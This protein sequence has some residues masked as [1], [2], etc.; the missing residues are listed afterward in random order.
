[1]GKD[2][3]KKED[4]FYMGTGRSDIVTDTLRGKLKSA[5]GDDFIEVWV[6]YSLELN[7]STDVRNPKRKSA[8]SAA[9]T[10]T[11]F[12]LLPKAGKGGKPRK[13]VPA[14]NLP[15]PAK[16]RIF[17]RLTRGPVSE[18]PRDPT[19]CNQI[20]GDHPRRVIH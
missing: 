16:H 13:L 19:A 11:V 7:L 18:H 15:K 5:V 4:S 8:W 10:E 1:M 12:A 2:E 14:V 9:N 17:A 3:T 6:I 20:E